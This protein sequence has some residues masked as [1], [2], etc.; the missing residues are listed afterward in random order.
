[1]LAWRRLAQRRFYRLTT[2]WCSLQ[3]ELS[4]YNHG[5]SFVRR[6]FVN[7]LAILFALVVAIGGCASQSSKPATNEQT[8]QTIPSPG[9]PRTVTDLSQIS[10]APAAQMKMPQ[11]NSADNPAVDV[12][13]NPNAVV[14]ENIERLFVS[15]LDQ[16]RYREGRPNAPG[17][18]RLLNDK[19]RQFSEFSYQLLN[20]TL[21]AA[22]AI[23]P[24][25]L[26]GRKLPEDIAPMVLTAVMDSKG[27]LT[28][29]SIESHSG[30]HQIDQIIIDSCK[31]GLWSR[32]PPKQ[33]LDEDGTY[34]LQINGYIRAYSFDLK[35]RYKYETE[36]GLGIL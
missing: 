15:N 5:L 3:T 18:I 9:E 27:R 7:T 2:F 28:E 30:N 23:E 14:Q 12:K 20:Q 17:D 25:R 36:L 32:N 16:L 26:E 22:R 10:S 11:L 24:D 19:A 35:G 31:Q 34:R 4:Y 21:T 29:I 13:R 8:A 6:R 1:M 33:A